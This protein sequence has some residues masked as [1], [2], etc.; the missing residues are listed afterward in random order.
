MSLDKLT[1]TRIKR[2]DSSDLD[3][4]MIAAV[5]INNEIIPAEVRMEKLNAKQIRDALHTITR[6]ERA[7]QQVIIRV[8]QGWQ[9]DTS[10]VP[11]L[12]AY[13]KQADAIHANNDGIILPGDCVV[14]SRVLHK[15]LLEQLYKGHPGMVKKMSQMRSFYG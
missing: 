8:Q 13:A 15:S 14:I 1:L 7:L 4:E 12:A 11:K 2:H 6:Q 10:K 9:G 3:M 5:H